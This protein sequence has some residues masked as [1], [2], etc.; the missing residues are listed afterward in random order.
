MKIAFTSKGNDLDYQVDARFGR[1]PFIII[2]N[3]EDKSFEVID[4]QSSADEAH[5]AGPKTAQKLADYD[6][7]V[8]ITGNG[9]G[10]NAATLIE[11]LQIE[12]YIGAADMPILEA[13]EQYK[14]N[15]LKKF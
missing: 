10:G 8:L 11:K 7:E 13:L 4:N 14:K 6:C 5:G 12:V 9:P 2:L 15:K 1:C 3:T